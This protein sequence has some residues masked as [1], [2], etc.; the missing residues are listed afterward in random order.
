[1]L[2]NAASSDCDK[3]SHG[4]LQGSI[5]GP[6]PFLKYVYDLPKIL[7]NISIPVLFT[8]DTSVI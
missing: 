6:L 8:D 4:V 2:P 3:I 7:S 1:M 5:F